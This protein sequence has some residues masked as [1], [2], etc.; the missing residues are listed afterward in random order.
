MRIGESRITIDE[1]F[2]SIAGLIPLPFEAKA[3]ENGKFVPTYR[4]HHR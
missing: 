3:L 1:T 4:I 2:S